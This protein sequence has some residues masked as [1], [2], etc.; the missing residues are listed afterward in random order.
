ARRLLEPPVPPAADGVV[1][2]AQGAPY[3]RGV[4]AEPSAERGVARERRLRVRA[5]QRQE[6]PGSRGEVRVL[7]GRVAPEPPALHEL[8]EER[9]SLGALAGEELLDAPRD[10]LRALRGERRREERGHRLPVTPGEEV[11][12][13]ARAAEDAPGARVEARRE[14]GEHV[15]L[16]PAIARGD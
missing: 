13:V 1:E 11:A 8:V 2:R 9:A 4:V 10:E 3:A 7:L 15:R 12:P 14:P 6:D 16:R 5:D